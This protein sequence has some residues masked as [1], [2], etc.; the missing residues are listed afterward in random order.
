MR[1]IGGCCPTGRPPGQRQIAAD[2]TGENLLRFTAKTGTPEC[3]HAYTP[4]KYVSGASTV[5][6]AAAS[7]TRPT[8]ME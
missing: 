1:R 4:R 5:P 3:G 7:K 6:E 2:K 8:T